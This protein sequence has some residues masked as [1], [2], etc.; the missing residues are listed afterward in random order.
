MRQSDVEYLFTAEKGT[1][2]FTGVRA[3][4]TRVIRAGDSLELEAF[5]VIRGRVPCRRQNRHGPTSNAQRAVNK[6]QR[7]KKLRRLIEANFTEV[8]YIVE[9]VFQFIP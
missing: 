1:A 2:D 6:R 3:M 9:M 7:A 4:R 5:P 8:D